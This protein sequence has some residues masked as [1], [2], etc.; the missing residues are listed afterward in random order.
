MGLFGKSKDDKPKKVTPKV[1]WEQYY[2]ATQEQQ[3]AGAVDVLRQ[4]QRR[5]PGSPKIPMKLGDALQRMGS[6]KEAIAAYH[7]AAEATVAGGFA[8]KALAIYKIILR[9]SPRDERAAER[10]REIVEGIESGA[11]ASALSAAA[12][13]GEAAF[14]GYGSLDAPSQEQTPDEPAEVPPLEGLISMETEVEVE[15]PPELEQTAYEDMGGDPQAAYN[16]MEAGPDVESPPELEQ[17]AYEDTADVPPVESLVEPEPEPEVETPP[18]LE[19]T[20]YEDSS[21]ASPDEA[22]P[23]GTAMEEELEALARPEGT[24]A[25]PQEFSL[26]EV[27]SFLIPDEQ[28]QFIAK[29]RPATYSHGEA[30]IREG[31][32]G[33][34]MYIVRQGTARVVTDIMGREVELALL[35]PGD[36]FGEVAF[37]TGRPRTASVV[38]MGEV[39]LLEVDKPLLQETIDLNPLILDGLVELYH[40][41]AQ[42]TVNRIK[43]G[44]Q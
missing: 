2:R 36:F 34:T 40:A 8:Q 20:A 1:L 7:Q 28:E 12:T 23:G 11:A 35:G 38:A 3:W 32:T 42:E 5:E 9:L 26:P 41:R 4:L 25:A 18:G 39:E 17:T 27:F 22:A 33:D 43:G 29:A 37:L 6:T 14:E 10:S 15:A 24:D 30:I 13:T 16:L 19:Q 21:G 31:E 44:E